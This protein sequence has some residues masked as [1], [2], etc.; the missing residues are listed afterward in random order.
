MAD[1]S[2]AIE[3]VDHDGCS[4]NLLIYRGCGSHLPEGCGLGPALKA[5]VRV[6]WKPGSRSAKRR[7][8]NLFWG[9]ESSIQKVFRESVRLKSA[10]FR[11]WAGLN[12]NVKLSG[13]EHPIDSGENSPEW[14]DPAVCRSRVLRK[15]DGVR[16][17][18]DRSKRRQV[19]DR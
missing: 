12:A 19:P 16:P 9:E 4:F 1:E 13:W 18:A 5:S 17:G 15:I 10:G 6:L 11:S 14:L 3:V 2:G 7:D 8:P